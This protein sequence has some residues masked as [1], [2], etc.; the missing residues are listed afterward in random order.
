MSL[1]H[2]FAIKISTSLHKHFWKDVNLIWDSAKF[3]VD[4]LTLVLAG[5][6]KLGFVRGGVSAYPTN[7]APRHQTCFWFKFFWIDS[8]WFFKNLNWYNSRIKIFWMN[9]FDS[10]HDSSDISIN[11]FAGLYLLIGKSYQQIQTCHFLIS[12]IHLYFILVIMST[13]QKLIRLDSWIKQKSFDPDS[14]HDS[15]DSNQ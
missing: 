2:H 10:I 8:K 5:S 7:S 9:W 13:Q 1:K 15:Y 12:F 3:G 11:W 6:K 14:I 4:V